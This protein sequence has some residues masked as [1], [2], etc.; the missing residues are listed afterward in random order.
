MIAYNEANNLPR[1]LKAVDKMGEL[2][3]VD[4]AS[5]DATAHIARSFGAKVYDRPF[6]NYANQKN[7]AV[8]KA[9]NEWI[10]SLDADEVLDPR[11]KKEILEIVA[12]NPNAAYRI[13]R[14]SY[15]FGKFLR[16]SGTQNDKP[17]RLFKKSRA[18]FTQPIHEYIQSDLPVRETQYGMLHYTYP[19]IHSYMKRLNK[20]TASEAQM[21]YEQRI[22]ISSYQVWI[23]AFGRFIQLY[24]FRL[25]F[26][27]GHQGW[28]F[29]VLSAYYECLKVLKYK[30]LQMKGT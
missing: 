25:G 1:C 8:S 2:I 21:L 22:N 14:K 27:D 24:I 10:L 26:L 15:I 5:A 6:D 13:Q 28:A 12:K 19:T 29:C 23:R 7:Y 18:H 16:Y 17:I 20:Y 11:L 4:S 30:E 9:S 3:V